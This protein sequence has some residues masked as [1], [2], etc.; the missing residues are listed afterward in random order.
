[1]MSVSAIPISYNLEHS[2]IP[3]TSHAKVELYGDKGFLQVTSQSGPCLGGSAPPPP[4]TQEG[5]PSETLKF[6]HFCSR[7][8]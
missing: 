3:F 7:S 1:M 4:K 2:N 6:A 8:K 5:A